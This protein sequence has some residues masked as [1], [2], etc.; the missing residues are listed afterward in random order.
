MHELDKYIEREI[1]PQFN[2]GKRRR[3]NPEYNA[4][5]AIRNPRDHP[6]ATADE[7]AEALNKMRNLP[8]YDMKDNNYRRSMYIRYAD[9]FVYLL[10]GPKAEA[11]VVKERIKIFLHDNIGLELNDDKTKITHITE[12]FHFLGAFIKM[13]QRVGFMMKNITK[14]GDRITMRANTRAGVYM[15][16][17]KLIDKLIGAKFAHRNSSNVLLASPKTELVNLDHAT[18]IQF[19]NSKIHGLINYYSFA[20]NRIEIQNLV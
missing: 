14:T 12:G 16:T 13:A 4:V 5:A 9:D 11:L 19:Y 10:E 18:I 15:P 7:K 20:S 3:T 8:R 17:E 6:N 2:R 1:I